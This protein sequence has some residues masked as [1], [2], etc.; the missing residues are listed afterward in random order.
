MSSTPRVLDPKIQA[1]F[2]A[3]VTIL[4][5]VMIPVSVFTGLKQSVPFLVFLSLWALVAG[6]WSAWQAARAESSANSTD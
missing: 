5:L 4:W 6:H 3:A 1:R 2:H